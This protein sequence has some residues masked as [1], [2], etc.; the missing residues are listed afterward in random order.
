[1]AIPRFTINSVSILDYIAHDGL[2]WSKHDVDGPN[3]GRNMNGTMIRDRVATKIR[4]DIKCRPLTSSEI[5][6][7]LG[8]LTGDTVTVRYYDPCEGLITKAMY[9]NNYSVT[10][11][12][13]YNDA[14]GL[15]TGLEFPLIEI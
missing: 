14:T 9:A 15:W 12:I 8:L 1:M 6:S 5:L 10:E 3:A 13:M 11:S 2:K 4:I 7:V